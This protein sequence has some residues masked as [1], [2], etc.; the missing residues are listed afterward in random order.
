MFCSIFD[1]KLVDFNALFQHMEKGGK[2]RL[3]QRFWQQNQAKPSQAT[4]TYLQPSQAS[5][6]GVKAQW[7]TQ[8]CSRLSLAQWLH[9]HL[10]PRHPASQAQPSALA[11]SPSNQQAAKPHLAVTHLSSQEVRHQYTA[12]GLPQQP[13]ASQACHSPSHLCNREAGHQ[14]TTQTI[15]NSCQ[16]CELYIYLHLH[17][18]LISRMVG[19]STIGSTS[20]STRP[21]TSSSTSASTPGSTCGSTGDS[22]SFK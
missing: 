11:Q 8:Q 18:D 15:T 3:K 9:N 5:E 12:C 2:S 17:L 10:G 6:P 21:S 13:R 20:R 1:L 4:V 19:S 14:Q 16:N 22:T 7:A